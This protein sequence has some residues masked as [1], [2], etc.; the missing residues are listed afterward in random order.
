MSETK[1]CLHFF[2]SEW[3]SEQSERYSAGCTSFP[4]RGFYFLIISL[5]FSQFCGTMKV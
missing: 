3:R 1:K 5:T 4:F 2:V